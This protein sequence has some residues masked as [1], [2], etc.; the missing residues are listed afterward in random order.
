MSG[1]LLIDSG[2]GVLSSVPCISFFGRIGG[3]FGVIEVMTGEPPDFEG[4]SDVHHVQAEVQTGH[5][6]AVPLVQLIPRPVRMNVVS[7]ED[8]V[9]DD[10]AFKP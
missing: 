7:V 10:Q 4:G 3:R 6:G 1:T 2:D 5:L 9:V 8:A